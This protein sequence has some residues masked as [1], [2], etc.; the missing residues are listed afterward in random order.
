MTFHLSSCWAGKYAEYA[1][2][3]LARHV[4]NGGRKCPPSRAEIIAIVLRDPY[5]YLQPLSAPVHLATGSEFLVGF[6]SSTTFQEFAL[7]VSLSL[8]LRPPKESGFAVFSNVHGSDQLIISEKPGRKVCDALFEWER[9][10]KLASVGLLESSLV[11]RFQFARRLYFA[12]HEDAASKGTEDILVVFQT[13]AQIMARRFDVSLDDAITLGT[14]VAQLEGG[15]LDAQDDAKAEVDGWVQ[16]CVPAPL[17]NPSLSAEVDEDA[18]PR[19]SAK[20][21][22]DRFEQRWRRSADES[23]ADLACSFLQIARKWWLYGATLVKAEIVASKRVIWCGI[24]EAGIDLLDESNFALLESI[25]YPNIRTFGGPGGHFRLQYRKGDLGRQ[26]FVLRFLEPV[27]HR[28]VT[29][30]MASYINMI[31]RSEG[32]TCTAAGIHQD[33]EDHESSLMA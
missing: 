1:S 24:N 17:R 8:G 13:F 31:V 9:K 10:A 26:E 20:E 14:I 25:L 27:T 33:M 7:D 29:H 5:E 18:P 30:R 22:R 15:N 12:S 21:I 16:R 19:L 23:S 6:D 28:E 11:P 4:E 3:C 32:M 2:S